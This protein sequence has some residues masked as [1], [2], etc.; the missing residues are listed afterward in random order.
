M[1]SGIGMVKDTRQRRMQLLKRTKKYIRRFVYS[2][3]RILNRYIC[4]IGFDSKGIY[5]I[6]AKQALFQLR[7]SKLYLILRGNFYG[8]S[9]TGKEVYVFQRLKPKG[10]ILKFKSDRDYWL[11]SPEIFMKDLSPGCHQLDIF[12]GKL[13]ICDSYNN[14]I[15]ETDLNDKQNTKHY[16]P[17]GKLDNGKESQNYGHMNSIFINE[18]KIIIMCH[19]TTQKTGRPSQILLLGRDCSILEEID[20]P[21]GSAH[22]VIPFNDSFLYCDSMNGN[23]NLG[24]KIIFKAS[25]FTRGL[26]VSDSYILMGGGEYASR[27]VREYGKGYLFILDKNSLKLLHKVDLTSM[28]QEI[29]RLDGPDIGLSENTK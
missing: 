25:C 26:S 14:R 21:A 9:K 10:K 27:D 1:D 20:A 13:Y 5:L 17:L 23:L 11:T 24:N 6:A 19:N 16:Y 12:Q 3:P 15:I 4:D 2:R 28:V 18:D 7:G 29:R 22:N 8:T